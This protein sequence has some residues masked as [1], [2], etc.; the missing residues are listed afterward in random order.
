MRNHLIFDK[1][2]HHLS[3]VL[4]V[5]LTEQRVFWAALKRLRAQV[6]SVAAGLTMNESPLA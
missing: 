2:D 5:V 4:Q 1:I 6:K 3:R